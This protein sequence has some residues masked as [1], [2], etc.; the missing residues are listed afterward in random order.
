MK[1]SP[2]PYQHDRP[3]VIMKYQSKGIHIPAKLPPEDL[4]PPSKRPKIESSMNMLKTLKFK[5]GDRKN[6]I[7]VMEETPVVT[8]IVKRKIPEIRLN[9]RLLNLTEE[10]KLNVVDEKKDEKKTIH[11]EEKKVP[12]EVHRPLA[13]LAP[14]PVPRQGSTLIMGNAL[15]LVT[16]PPAVPAPPPPQAPPRRRLY[17]CEY[18]NCNKNYFKSS[19]L[20]AHLR[21]HTGEK[22]FLCAWAD[23]GRKF[24]RSDELSRHKRTH[25]GEKKFG[26]HVCDRKF[27]RSDHLAKHV[28]RH[29]RPS[30]PARASAL[31]LM[32]I[33]EV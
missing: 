27:M 19:H 12:K 6:R 28:K 10:K 24:S 22:P 25:T 8:E 14:R 31:P 29:E 7:F 2:L 13:P 16:A 23:C 3:S 21:T 4:P 30:P 33:Y 5:M 15:W 20:K 9:D 32:T 17:E 26:C 1:P 11:V 18:P